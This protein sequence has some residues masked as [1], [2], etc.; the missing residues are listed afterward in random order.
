[1]SVP[2][3]GRIR[4]N[5]DEKHSLDVFIQ[6]VTNDP[7]ENSLIGMVNIANGL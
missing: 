4:E 3:E 6:E 7:N 1:M 5:W 2:S